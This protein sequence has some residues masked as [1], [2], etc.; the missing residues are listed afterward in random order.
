MGLRALRV[1]AHILAL[2][3]PQR[4][5]VNIHIRQAAHIHPKM[6]GRGA[7]V[8]KDIY[9]ADL[10]EIMLRDARIPLIEGERV[11]ARRER[12]IRLRHFHHHRAAHRAERAITRR[13]LGEG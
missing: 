12:Q 5:G 9:P 2:R 3:G 7:L 8:V 4:R 10:A 1:Y 11:L 13:K 6:I